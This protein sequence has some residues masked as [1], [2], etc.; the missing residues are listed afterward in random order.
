MISSQLFLGG[1]TRGRVE[2]PPC[3]IRN[4]QYNASILI[5]TL[6]EAT[7]RKM[8]SDPLNTTVPQM[9][10]AELPYR[11]EIRISVIRIAGLEV[12]LET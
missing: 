2:I 12:K 10:A 9:T 1:F 6:S 4:A 5:G 8:D 7:P 11:Y 3:S